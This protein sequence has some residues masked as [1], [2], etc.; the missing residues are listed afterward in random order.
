MRL[1]YTCKDVPRSYMRELVRFRQVNKDV[2]SIA[3]ANNPTTTTKTTILAKKDLDESASQ[4][5]MTSLN[6]FHAVRLVKHS[7]N[8]H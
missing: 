6:E 2:R 4:Q 1:Y 5:A 3:E 8:G 7:L